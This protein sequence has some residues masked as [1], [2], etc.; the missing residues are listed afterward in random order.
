VERLLQMA[1]DGRLEPV[2]VE[3]PPLPG[4][5]TAPMRAVADFF[6]LVCGVRLWAGEDRS[7]PFACGWVAE[8]LE[9]P[10]TTVH[11]ALRQLVSCGVLASAGSMPGR[12]GKRGTH[13]YEPGVVAAAAGGADVIEMHM[14]RP[15]STAAREAS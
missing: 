15:A 1:A 14:A 7:A 10:K 3:L 8:K 5:A 13:L 2:P 12:G 11:R 9:L 6:A 4:S